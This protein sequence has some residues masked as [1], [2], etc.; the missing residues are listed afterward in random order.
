MPAWKKALISLS[1]LV[2]VLGG[3]WLA[4]LLNWAGLKSPLPRFQ[5]VEVVEEVADTVVEAADTLALEVV[6]TE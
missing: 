2:V 5:P 1:A 4:N 6:A 3:L